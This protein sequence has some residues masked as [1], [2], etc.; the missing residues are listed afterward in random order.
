MAG[1]WVFSWQLG[2][3]AW[4]RLAR[5][6][7]DDP[8]RRPPS[9]DEGEQALLALTDIGA[10]RRLLDQ[11][12]FEAIRIARRSGRSW[13][14]V[15]VRLGITRQS[16]WERWQDVDKPDQPVRPGERAVTE[17]VAEAVAQRV[18][19]YRW[20]RM[21]G[22]TAVARRSWCPTWSA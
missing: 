13:A 15:A 4:E 17:A 3:R 18:D 7:K 5:W 20:L 21:L 16:A 19:P 6:G 11:T 9:G 10:L 22:H 1:D 12:E 14:E 2:T 8:E